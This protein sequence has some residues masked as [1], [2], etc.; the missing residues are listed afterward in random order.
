VKEI[1]EDIRNEFNNLKT[2]QLVKQVLETETNVLIVEN[3]CLHL[4][5]RDYKLNPHPH[6]DLNPKED[7]DMFYIGEWEDDGSKYGKNICY[8]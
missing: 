1:M 6:Y 3:G 7:S 2:S 8:A 4:S 5:W